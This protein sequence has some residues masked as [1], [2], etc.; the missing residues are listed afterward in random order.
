MSTYATFYQKLLDSTPLGQVADPDKL[1]FKDSAAFRSDAVFQNVNQGVL[2]SQGGKFYDSM[3]ATVMSAQ[4]T[5]PFQVQTSDGATLLFE[6]STT[7][8]KWKTN[9]VWHEGNFTKS[10][11][12]DTAFIN[13]VIFG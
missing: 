1:V 2:L 11:I 8:L 13:A 3:T 9:S 7:G 4:P 12:D 5:K 10:E 6:A